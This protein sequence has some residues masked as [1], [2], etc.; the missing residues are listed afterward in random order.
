MTL[1]FPNRFI[2]LI[3]TAIVLILFQS[4]CQPI[5]P[6]TAMPTTVT[7]AEEER[8][9]MSTYISTETQS[10]DGAWIATTLFQIPRG[11]ETFFQSLIVTHAS[12]APSYTL[13]E[14][15]FPLALGYTVTE[16]LTW[17]Q[18]GARFYYT[19]RPQADGCG[20]LFNGSDLHLLHLDSG[21]TEE[22][23]SANTTTT[24]GLAPDEQHV[25]Y[26]AMG[27]PTLLLHDLASGEVTPFDL[28]PLLEHAADE[29]SP[30][31]GAFVWSPDSNVL[32]FVVAHGPCINGWAQS[33]SLYVLDT[34]SMT[35]TARLSQDDR[36]LV[37]IAWSDDATLIVENQLPFDQ[38][39]R[40]TLDL[41]TN[42]VEPVSGQE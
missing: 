20:L 12:G 41:A 32:A 4:G 9:N 14:G 5:Q 6:P 2:W 19:N 15:D 21:A 17:S 31:V 1:N 34:Q 18:D 33:T 26:L 38:K 35:A 37:P 27:E 36:V 25:A 30:Q 39:H 8:A 10:P 13:I 42:T 40:F 29:A 23:L 11:S 28:A 24:I 7:S 22:I 3:I 16:P